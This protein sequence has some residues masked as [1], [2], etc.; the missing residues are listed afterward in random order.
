MQQK[1]NT[2]GSVYCSVI[3]QFPDPLQ[4]RPCIHRGDE[5]RGAQCRH[6]MGSDREVGHSRAHLGTVSPNTVGETNVLDQGRTPHCS[7]KR[8]YTSESLYLN[9]DEGVAF[10]EC[11]QLVLDHG[12]MTSCVC[13]WKVASA[14]HKPNGFT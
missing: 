5:K 13:C 14:F 7:S 1:C 3:V 4:L 12:T 11:W 9:R 2:L 8:I 10:P 6:Q